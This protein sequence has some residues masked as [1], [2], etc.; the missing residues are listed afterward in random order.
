MKKTTRAQR[1]PAVRSG[2]VGERVA[3]LDWAA[4]TSELDAHGCAVI[5]SLLSAA[6]C[7][8]VAEMYPD[9]ALFRR[10]VVMSHHGYGRGEYQ[11]FAYPLPPVVQSLRVSLYP[12]LA[13]VANRWNEAMGIDVRFPADHAGFVGRCHT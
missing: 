9:A 8:A 12:H 10:R 7:G 11:Y 4:L 6:E 1:P 2:D 3:A 5:P 13:P